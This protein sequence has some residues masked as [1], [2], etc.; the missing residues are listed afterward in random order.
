MKLYSQG[1]NKILA[2]IPARGGSKSIP[3]KNIKLLAGKP[4]IYWTIKAA[5]ESK[6]LNDTILSSDST[7][8]I[9]IAKSFGLNAPFIRPPELAEDKTPTLPVMQHAVSFMEKKH[10]YRYNY[11]VLLEPTSPLRISEDIDG[12]ITK[13]IK[14]GADSIITVYQLSDIHPIRCKR[15]ENDLLMPFCIVEKEGMPRQ[16]LPPAYYRNGS[17][18]VTKRDIIMEQ[19]SIWGT[20]S[21]P[22][23][24]P[25]DRSIDIDDE[26][27]FYV[28]EYYLRQV[29]K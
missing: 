12:A 20:I 8:I 19:N 17:V 28:A 23:V 3:K 4:L 1:R 5:Q 24:M 10:K 21:R 25:A 27:S 18:Y 16:S 7:E 6:L 26:S 9:D 14:T 13:A 2:I 15:I 11:I 22:Y 29:K